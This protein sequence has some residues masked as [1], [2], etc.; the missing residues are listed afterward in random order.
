MLL[1][2]NARSHSANLTKSTIQELGWE[3]IPHPPPSPDLTPSDFQLFCSLSNN[4]Q[5]TSFPDVNVLR[6]WLDVFFNSK[7]RDLYRRKIEKLLQRWQ[8]VVY[9]EGEYTNVTY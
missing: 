2:D 3:V 4:L 9:S 6:T 8:A 7:P 1:H 5:E